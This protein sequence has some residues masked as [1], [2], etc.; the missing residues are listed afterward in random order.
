MAGGFVGVGGTARKIKAVYVGVDGVARKITKAYVGVDGVAR[1]CFSSRTT[2]TSNGAIGTYPYGACYHVQ[3]TTAGYE[4]AVFFGGEH[5][6]RRTNNVYAYNSNFVASTVQALTYNG[7]G[8]TT[9]N[10]GE[11][12]FYFYSDYDTDDG[13]TTNILY[14]IDKNLLITTGTRTTNK[15]TNRIGAGRCGNYV[16]VNSWTASNSC[17]AFTDDMVSTQLANLPVANEWWGIAGNEHGCIFNYY[18][19]NAVAYSTDLVQTSTTPFSG[20]EYS[21]TQKGSTTSYSFVLADNYVSSWQMWNLDFVKT[22]TVSS[23]VSGSNGRQLK[24]YAVYASS[25]RNATCYAMSPEGLIA[26]YQC[27]VAATVN[28]IGNVGNSIIYG[29]GYSA[30]GG[31]YYSQMGALTAS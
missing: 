4:Y 21:N 26:A 14:T 31:V 3:G 11:K 13:D 30:N 12:G 25:N 10:T 6:N 15:Y 27:V 9:A 24:E 1:P 20:A 19:S 29:T 5:D 8:D 18:N 16:L 17:T 2:I 22:G 7:S 28:S 23:A